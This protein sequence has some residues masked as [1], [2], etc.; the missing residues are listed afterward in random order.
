MVGWA[1]G[2]AKKFPTAVWANIFKV[3]FCAIG[4]KGAL[5]RTTTG[6]RCICWQVLV[7]AFAVRFEYEHRLSFLVG[8]VCISPRLLKSDMA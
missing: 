6:V 3:I 2:S 8:N 4:A 7:A 1:Y 5:E